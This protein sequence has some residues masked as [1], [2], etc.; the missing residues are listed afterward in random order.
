MNLSTFGAN[1]YK[2]PE[3]A[4]QLKVYF[5]LQVV[6]IKF[7]NLFGQFSSPILREKVKCFGMND[8]YPLAFGASAI[9]M[10][11]AFLM[12]LCGKSL[13]VKTP[14]SENMVVKVCRCLAVRIV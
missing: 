12:F 5:S 11:T 8:C 3:Q 2:L 13:F 14:P 9:A 4:A 1:Q 10:V 6:F 7:G